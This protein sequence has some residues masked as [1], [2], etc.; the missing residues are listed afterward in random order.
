MNVSEKISW[1]WVIFVLCF[2][3][4]GSSGLRNANE[5]A[6]RLYQNLDK[7]DWAA[8]NVW[9]KSAE[10]ARETGAWLAIC[11][12]NKLLPVAQ[13]ALADDPGQAFLLG[14]IA[15]VKDRSISV[16]DVARL[17]IFINLLG[18]LA[19]AALLFAARL[20]VASLVVLMLCSVPYFSWV[21][22]SP[23]PGLIGAATMAA[24]LPM[25]I[26]FGE[27][28]YL[29]RIRYIL[30]LF[31]GA[32]LLGLAAMLRE[33]IGTMSLVISLGALV[34]VALNKT[35]K[36]NSLHQKTWLLVLLV[37][38]FFSW[39]TPRWALVVRDALFPV[40][41]ASL[42]QT[43]GISHN[44]YIGLGAGGENKF[45]IRWDDGFGDA[46][47]KSADPSVKYVSPEYFRILWREYLSRV[48]EDPLEV[49][50]IYAIKSRKILAHRLP[51]WAPP[52]WLVIIG[53]CALLFASYR[54]WG[55]QDAIG[56]GATSIVFMTA[57]AFIGMFIAQG[58][59]AHPAKQYAHPIG[60]FVLLAIAIGF[61][62]LARSGYVKP[63]NHKK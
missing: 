46:A 8:A 31:F 15:R 50:R 22:A 21:G 5:E 49:V 48:A 55:R 43:H 4:F 25:T 42:V 18:V 36:I 24:I 33:P 44:L 38:V 9:I 30:F 10:C 27:L 13:F 41:P 58:V 59:L 20:E 39:Q 2:L 56:F 17:N 28:G 52:L 1:R 11:S 3:T 47:V 29:S 32:A 63:G 54:R 23:H 57:L 60:G 61:E 34:Y 19:I 62:L 16:Y 53:S 45:G 35:K 14:L 12:E 26:L 40:Q 37:L 51:A 6:S 7:S